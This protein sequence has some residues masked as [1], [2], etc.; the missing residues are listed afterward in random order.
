[1]EN[2]VEFS[3]RFPH[4]KS[5]KNRQIPFPQVFHISLTRLCGKI[6]SETASQNAKKVFRLYTVHFPLSF[7]GGAQPRRGNPFSFSRSRIALKG[8]ADCRVASLLAMTEFLTAHRSFLPCHSEEGS[9]PDMGI[10]S[11]FP[12]PT[13]HTKGMRIAASLRSSQ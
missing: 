7:R 8:D 6:F 3:D 1:M 2:F 4:P 11:L 5:G 9:S 12:G 10:R 13:S